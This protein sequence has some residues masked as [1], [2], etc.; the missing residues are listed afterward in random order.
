MTV[1][2]ALPRLYDA[3]VATFAA[4]AAPGEAIPQAFGW[5]EPSRR[6]ALRIVWV[7]GDDASGDLGELGAARSPGRDPRPLATV[8][9]LATVY[10]E[11]ADSSAPENE[12]AQYVAAR[13]LFDAWLRAVYLAARGTFVVLSSAWV[14]DKKER[15]YGAT[16]RVVLAIEA[17]VPD[18][19]S[20]LA[21][22]LRAEIETSLLDVDETTIAGDAIPEARAATTAELDDLA[23]EITVDGVALVD[24]DRLLVKDE[25]EF[26][27]LNGIWV[28][29]PGA[30]ARAE[31]DLDE[32]FF[33]HVTSGTTN[34]DAGFELV[35]E[36]PITVGV[37]PLV[38]E[39]VSP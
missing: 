6:G 2:L 7:P 20:T 37:T 24:G 27:E 29:A 23:G 35:T 13:L 32:G 5:R 36:D 22:Y 28:V 38:F 17:M 30:W 33:V 8:R 19:P 15:R 10:L 12:R 21:E 4:D 34:G 1:V 31:D 16:I 18:A 11:A 25:V 26:A 9:E 39:R 14:I 3:V